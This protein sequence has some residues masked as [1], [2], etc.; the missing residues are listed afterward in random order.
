MAVD[1]YQT[2]D[3]QAHSWLLHFQLHRVHEAVGR[4]LCSWVPVLRGSECHEAIVH[5]SGIKFSA[6]AHPPRSWPLIKISGKTVCSLSLALDRHGVYR[7]AA[8]E[9]VRI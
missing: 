3:N 8:L 6:K 1:I 9:L 7:R 5:F 4:L 2:F